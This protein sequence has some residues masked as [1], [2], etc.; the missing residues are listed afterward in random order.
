MC[1]YILYRSRVNRIDANVLWSEFLREH[2]CDSIDST[3]GSDIH[4]SLRLRSLA[5]YRTNIDHAATLTIEIFGRFLRG[6][7][8]PEHIGVELPVELFFGNLLEWSKL[9]TRRC[10]PGCPSHRTPSWFQQTNGSHRMLSRRHPESQ[11]H[12]LRSQRCPPRLAQ[13]PSLLE[14]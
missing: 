3:F 9:V 2:A 5:G 4:H 8:K 13:A 6:Q 1:P 12:V 10:S 11:S 7:K 14:A